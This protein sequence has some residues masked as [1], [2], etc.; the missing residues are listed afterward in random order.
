M[1]GTV[2]FVRARLESFA[3][4]ARFD[5]IILG[6]YGLSYVLEEAG[7]RACLERVRRHLSVDG[8]A[9][10]HLP[11]PALLSRT[12]PP[13]EL[14]GMRMR[15]MLPDRED[16]VGYALSFSVASMT[17][18][19]ERRQ[20]HVASRIVVTDGDGRVRFE[21]EAVMTYAHIDREDLTGLAAEAGLAVR[22]LSSGFRPGAS[23]EL[24]AVLAPL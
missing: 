8:L 20:R 14:A 17:Y 18:E 15:T 4:D 16:R 13:E 21:E 2:D 7:R 1:V 23:E 19:P 6:Y 9:V 11:A 12:V 24:V 5:L 22:E 10:V 3:F